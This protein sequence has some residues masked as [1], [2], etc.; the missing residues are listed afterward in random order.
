[1]RRWNPPA[2]ASHGFGV[3][4]QPVAKGSD[5]TFTVAFEANI[6]DSKGREV[7]VIA[8]DREQRSISYGETPF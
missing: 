7:L 8:A 4:T 3:A 1:M 6:I 5:A 2:C